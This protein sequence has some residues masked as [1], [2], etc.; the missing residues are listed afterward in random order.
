ME[1]EKYDVYSAFDIEKHKKKYIH[2]L[3]VLILE[4]G[5]V[6]YAVPSHQEL[7]IRLACEKLQITRKEL[8]ARCPKEY[9]FDYMNWLLMQTGSIAVWEEGVIA[10]LISSK[11]VA[12]LKQLKLAGLYKGTI[13]RKKS[14][15]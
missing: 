9:Y 10:P 15:S 14:V 7:A 1:N 8:E 3:E 4:D 6:M 13:P 12:K 2:Y 5:T 11:Q